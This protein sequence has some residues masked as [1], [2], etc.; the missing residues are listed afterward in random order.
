MPDDDPAAR[1]MIARGVRGRLVATVIALVALTSLVLGL[2]S[3]A[4]V[5]ASLRAQSLEAAREVTNFNVGVLAVERLP[6]SAS[7]ADLRASRLLDA[8]ALRG[9]SG[10]VVDLAGER[11]ASG[12]VAAGAF[13]Q[14][15]PE[16]RAV[17]AGGRI[18]YQRLSLDG[19]PYLVTG[20]RRPPDGPDFYFFFDESATETAIERLGQALAAGGLLLV[21]VAA[22]AGRALAR[23]LLRPVS[24]ASA[25][26]ERIAS[27]DLSARLAVDSADEFG[28]WADAFNRMA[29]SLEEKVAQL[30]AAE[31]RER[32]FVAD[33]SH[34]LRTPL[35]ALVAEAG[36][37]RDHLDRLPPDARRAGEL[38]VGD[39]ARLRTLVDDLMEISRFDAAAESV[40]ETEVELEAFLRAVVAAH[41]PEARTSMAGGP[42][43]VITDRRRLERILGNLL[44]NARLHGEGRDIGL[45]ASV[46]PAFG[47][48]TGTAL[49]GPPTAELRVVVSDAG[50]GVAPEELARLFDRFHKADP[51]RHRGGSG[52]GLAIAAEHARLL[53]GALTAGLREGGGLRFELRLPVTRPLPGGDEAVTVAVQPEGSSDTATEPMP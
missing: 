3:Y 49:G 53:G 45:E 33:V 35:T 21:G 31:A 39:V 7:A 34:E 1:P 12:F 19:R 8:F 52:L 25:A 24:D 15:A 18:G 27:G 40:A 10:T 9:A 48:A 30:Q 51:S 5:A 11:F 38:L 22:L 50:P 42:V 32:R 20:A 46:E 37:L 26:A 47:A 43:V 44:D 14:L 6:A 28:L 17:V 41:A 13:D 2:G 4:Y 36:L 23:R 29:A 16:L